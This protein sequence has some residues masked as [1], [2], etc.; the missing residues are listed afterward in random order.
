MSHDVEK[1]SRLEEGLKDKKKECRESRSSAREE[2]VCPS[3]LC[4]P[5]SAR[6]P[7][8]AAH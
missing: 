1:N 8:R 5:W 6:L 3:A 2:S 4:E 7:E